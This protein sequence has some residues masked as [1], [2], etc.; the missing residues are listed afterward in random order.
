MDLTDLRIREAIL[1][2]SLKPKL[3]RKEEASA[4]HLVV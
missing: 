2:E 1:I 4:F 3:N